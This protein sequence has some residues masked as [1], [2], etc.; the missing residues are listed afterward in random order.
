MIRATDLELE[1]RPIDPLP[2]VVALLPPAAAVVETEPAPRRYPE[3]AIAGQPF[4]VRA[5]AFAPDLDQ[6]LVGVIR[7]RPA[8]GP[9]WY[10]EPLHAEGENRFTGSWTPPEVG[11]FEWT[12]E[13][14]LGEDALNR[15]G[16]SGAETL[17]LLRAER[18]DL[19][20]AHWSCVARRPLLDLIENAPAEAILLLPPVFALNGNGDIGREDLGHYTIDP[21]LGGA[22]HRDSADRAVFS[23][24]PSPPSARADR[25]GPDTFHAVSA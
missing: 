18:P 4:E 2:S 13:L 14:W 23:A 24:V 22:H 20:T 15:P 25:T 8:F 19:A 21:A 17:H 10:E 5:R 6:P 9:R 12:V 1:P 16:S 3:L 7:W 11:D